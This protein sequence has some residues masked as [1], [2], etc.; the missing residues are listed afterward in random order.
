[1]INYLS[2]VEIARTHRISPKL[3]GKIIKQMKDNPNILK[4]LRIKKESEEK[5]RKAI[6]QETL[7]MTKFW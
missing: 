5:A 6:S 7:R 4:E 1:M 2:H 3:V